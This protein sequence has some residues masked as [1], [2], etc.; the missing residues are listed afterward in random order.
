M[1]CGFSKYETYDNIIVVENIYRKKDE[2]F[3]SGRISYG[4]MTILD[5]LYPFI[6]DIETDEVSGTFHAYD[7][8]K[9]ELVVYE[10]DE[11]EDSLI[12]LTIYAE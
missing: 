4:R 12:L 3:N 7:L 10:D 2:E 8:S 6:V 5:G 9:H 1:F 11:D